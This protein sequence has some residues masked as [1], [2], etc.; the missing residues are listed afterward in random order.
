MS[1]GTSPF[2]TGQRWEF[3]RWRY[4]RGRRFATCWRRSH[5][6]MYAARSPEMSAI[7]ARVIWKSLGPTGTSVCQAS[8]VYFFYL[9]VLDLAFSA[10][11]ERV[12]KP[13][14]TGKSPRAWK[15]LASG[16][17]EIIV[18]VPFASSSSAELLSSFQSR[19]L[20][21]RRRNGAPHLRNSASLA[22]RSND[23]ENDGSFVVLSDRYNSVG[24]ASSGHVFFAACDLV[25][26]VAFWLLNKLLLLFVMEFPP[27]YTRCLWFS[28]SVSSQSASVGVV[29]V[30]IAK[31]DWK[32]NSR[33][34]GENEN[35][36]FSRQ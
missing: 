36:S 1:C 13:V 21:V 20:S 19:F 22:L 26:G 2:C 12:K 34:S 25:S 29:S 31:T 9:P 18:T 24:E 7:W 4:R 15:K 32:K 23:V 5:C 16:C 30:S 11:M 28:I 35:Y 14:I 3:R 10:N 33:R 27:F 6:R 8:W 17:G